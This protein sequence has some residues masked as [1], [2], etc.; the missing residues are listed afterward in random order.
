MP[1]RVRVVVQ[2][3]TV[4]VL[5]GGGGVGAAVDLSPYALSSSLAA[6]A[7][8]GSA[9]DLVVGT[10]PPAR[11]G[12]GTP[13]AATYLQGDSTWGTPLAT[14]AD[15]DR[16]DVTVSAAGTV[17]T[18]DAVGGA[19]AAALASHLSATNVHG[20]SAY[21]AS[22]VD[23]ATDAEARTTLG[24]G[25]SATRNVGT[26]AGTVA[27]GDHTH[28]AAGDAPVWAVL[29]ADESNSTT[30]PVDALLSF[31]PAA[32]TTYLIEVWLRFLTAASTTGLRWQVYDGTGGGDS[33]QTI[34]APL[35]ATSQAIRL[36]HCDA[37]NAVLGTGTG[38]GGNP[39]LA[40][41]WALISAPA[42]PAGSISIW[43][44]S[45]IAGSAVTL[46]A[47]SAMRI[48]PIA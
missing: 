48:T 18:V 36:S 41:G 14:L 35:S 19:S 32:D 47:G 13:S 5:V 25:D 22:L 11:L 31:T 40:Y 17:W 38:A 10:V 24:L 21:A 16:G 1:D 27:A 4:N 44:H 29:A 23:D 39:G 2:R 43:Y 37:G 9:A 28:A 26:A 12:A 20:I 34:S 30:T 45:E 42:S 8:T 46:R 15:G 33:N 7:T 6:I 3:P